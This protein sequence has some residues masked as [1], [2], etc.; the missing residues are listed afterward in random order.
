MVP[1]T[2][3][4]DALFTPT[5][6]LFAN[7]MLPAQVAPFSKRQIDLVST[8]ADQAVIAINNVGLFEEVQARTREL[9]E[10]LEN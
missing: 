6:V 10:S 7:V 2:A 1:V 3:L 4:E 8:F 9:T 5:R